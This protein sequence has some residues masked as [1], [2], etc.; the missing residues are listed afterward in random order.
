MSAAATLQAP[1]VRALLARADMYRLLA[2][3]FSY[4]DRRGLQALRSLLDEVLEHG[5]ARG[6][7]LEDATAALATASRS[8]DAR[9]ARLAGEH[10]RLFA[11]QVECS[12]H[13]TEYEFDPFSKA[14]QLADICGFYKAF[15]LQ[16]AEERR[17]LPDFVATELEFLSFLALKEAYAAVQGWPAE[18]QIA[19]DAQRSFLEDHAGR[20]LP[21][22]ARKL[23]GLYVPF[24]SAAADLLGAFIASEIER[25]GANP[26]PLVQRGQLAGDDAEAFVCGLELPRD[27]DDEPSPQ[28]VTWFDDPPVI[29]ATQRPGG[30]G[31]EA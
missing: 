21:A 25:L 10:T 3:A 24:Y 22:F 1:E 4:P 30:G 13:E 20:W 5:V 8:R 14:R 17:G 19:A 26:L 2:Q 16:V 7:A 18:R 12:G 15:G 11:G 27:G 31:D 9:P 28:M 6:L 29:E 23:A